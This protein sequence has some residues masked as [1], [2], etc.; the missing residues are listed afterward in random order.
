MSMGIDNNNNNLA[1]NNITSKEYKHIGS[2][3]IKVPDMDFKI[4]KNPQKGKFTL[5]NQLM[6]KYQITTFVANKI[7]ELKDNEAECI[8]YI[9]QV[10]P[11]THDRY[12][13]A[14]AQELFEI[15]HNFD[16][17]NPDK[18]A[19]KKP[20][21][22]PVK[23]P[24]KEH[25]VE[26]VVEPTHT[27]V[28]EAVIEPEDVKQVEVT[29]EPVKQ[30]EN[31]DYE[32]I[33]EASKKWLDE[34][35]AKYGLSKTTI[36]DKFIECEQQGR[37]IGYRKESEDAEKGMEDEEYY[38]SI[39]TDV[40]AFMIIENSKSTKAK[41]EH[42]EVIIEIPEYNFKFTII[43]DKKY[44]IKIQDVEMW[45]T[46]KKSLFEF[47]QNFENEFTAFIIK[48][49]NFEKA[50]AVKI[51][52][53]FHMQIINDFHKDVLALSKNQDVK[54]QQ[55]ECKFLG[56]NVPAD[57]I[58]EDGELKSVRYE[59]DQNDEFIEVKD[60]ISK[61]F[62][63][64]SI[65]VIKD[66]GEFKNVSHVVLKFLNE[67]GKEEE[68]SINENEILDQRTPS[69]KLQPLSI[70]GFERASFTKYYLKTKEI[71]VISPA[72]VTRRGGWKNNFTQYVTGNK[73]IGGDIEYNLID[74]KSMDNIH[75]KGTMDQWIEGSYELLNDEIFAF[76]NYTGVA[77]LIQKPLGLSNSQIICSNETSS[78]KTTGAR[79]RN[80]GFGNPFH[81]TITANSS[82]LGNQNVIYKYDDAPVHLDEITKADIPM[83][84]EIVYLHSSGK[85]RTVAK[86]NGNVRDNKNDNFCNN[87]FITTEEI[88]FDETAKGGQLVRSIPILRKPAR[89]P[90]AIRK[91]EKL[92]CSKGE[93]AKNY[94]YCVEPLA[95]K[96][97]E[98]VKD[99]S[100]ESRF[101]EIEKQL[102]DAAGANSN[103][104][105][106]LT[107]IYTSF[108]LAGEIF[109]IVIVKHPE[110]RGRIKALDPIAIT[111]MMLQDYMELEPDKPEGER[112]MECFMSWYNANKL[113][114]NEPQP[115]PYYDKESD[116]TEYRENKMAF[117]G[118]DTDPTVIQ[119]FSSEL[120]TVIEKAGFLHSSVLTK[121]K[122][123]EY[124]RVKGKKNVSQKKF[125]PQHKDVMGSEK[126]T[127]IEIFKDKVKHLID[128]AVEED[129]ANKNSSIIADFYDDMMMLSEMISSIS[130]PKMYDA[131]K[132][133]C[134]SNKIIP[135][136]IL[137]FFI[138][139]INTKKNIAYDQEDPL[140]M[141][142]IFFVSIGLRYEY[143]S[144]PKKLNLSLDEEISS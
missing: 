61:A 19:F 65:G 139:F 22:E 55:S 109:N 80:S 79:L 67:D 120:K 59:M 25:I 83:A 107:E 113:K 74:N 92:I 112:A 4:N 143:E 47:N 121:W 71:N 46:C 21:T 3:A 130:L 76:M 18:N 69:D 122:E 115:I 90:E 128:D 77:N 63:I 133:W 105:N 37:K 108:A 88:I 91:F 31:V 70:V 41:K 129:S 43:H 124:I 28:V 45:Y 72:N 85:P 8:E 111:T 81:M 13:D 93:V 116:T 58:I 73:T 137:S 30:E 32:S 89:N 101:L 49:G 84:R 48:Y 29:P 138:Q 57:Y 135:L 64:K 86:T 87:M 140:D 24:V 118:Y 33:P 98:M 114:F 131:Y 144:V 94:G 102:R 126:F 52:T 36:Y 66:E 50:E 142:T 1:N 132:L 127:C 27:P 78:G 106:R 2:N 42:K 96:V 119:V 34:R 56:M 54:P 103:M 104:I 15:V 38:D 17:M 99:G 20:V 16:V 53:N 117:Y 136:N 82:K 75:I 123:C 9:N 44:K 95:L 125:A 35:I 7:Y 10:I 110:N 39:H 12:P 11:N 62:T 23:E 14:Y 68:I 134:N 40:N 100:L 26:P 60:Y 51:L 141:N 6:S 97:M 5:L